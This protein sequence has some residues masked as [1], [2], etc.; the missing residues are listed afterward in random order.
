MQGMA[1]AGQDNGCGSLWFILEQYTLAL[2]FAVT[3]NKAI[4]C[5]NLFCI[6][7]QES[8]VFSCHLQYHLQYIPIDIVIVCCFGRF[9]HSEGKQVMI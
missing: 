8:I 2:N 4:R 9:E 1:L 3:L 5:E 7:I 6:L